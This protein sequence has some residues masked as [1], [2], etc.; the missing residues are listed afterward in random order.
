M[1]ILLQKRP[2]ILQVEKIPAKKRVE[3]VEKKEESKCYKNYKFTCFAKIISEEIVEMNEILYDKLI[4]VREVHQTAL[5]ISNESY[6][7]YFNRLTAKFSMPN[8]AVCIMNGKFAELREML[9]RQCSCNFKI[10]PYFYAKNG[11]CGL[12]IEIIAAKI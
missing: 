8:N 12:K 1:D 2:L 4:K 9:G 7:S 5:D 6:K 11:D 10:T 3:I